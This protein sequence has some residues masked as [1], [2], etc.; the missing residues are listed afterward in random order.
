MKLSAK[1]KH[2]VKAM[3]NLALNTKNK[4]RTLIELAKH[5]GISLSY[6]EQLFALLRKGNLVKGARG[7]GG[8]YTLS[9]KPNDIT[10]A[11]ILSAI[12]I[13]NQLGDSDKLDDKIWKEFS[14]KLFNYLDTITLDSIVDKNMEETTNINNDI[15]RRLTAV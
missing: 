6:L 1:E 12:N 15:D 14:H 3:I 7:P 2:A 10:I 13:T 5:Q 8:G 4:P 9:V 11:Q